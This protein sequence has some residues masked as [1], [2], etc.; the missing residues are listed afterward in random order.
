MNHNEAI[1]FARRGF[2]VTHPSIGKAVRNPAAFPLLDNAWALD[3]VGCDCV[4]RENLNLH[5]QLSVRDTD[6]DAYWRGSDD[7]TDSIVR[8]LIKS[9]QG[10]DVGGGVLAH[11]G[12]ETLRREILRLVE[13]E[14]RQLGVIAQLATQRNEAVARVR[15]LESVDLQGFFS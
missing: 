11:E 15:E 8:I 2:R 3:A 4:A 12:L 7:A 10:S 1:E 5:N 9:V 14:S 6:T 13:T